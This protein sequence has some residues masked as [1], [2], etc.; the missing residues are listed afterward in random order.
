MRSMEGLR[1]DV[2]KSC[3]QVVTIADDDRE[4][5][6]AEVEKE[7]W[8]ALLKLAR[9]AIALFLARRAAAPRPLEYQHDG[10]DYVLDR[11][12]LAQSE[13]GTRFG[14]VAFK[15][16]VGRRADGRRGS[17]DL[18]SIANSGSSVGSASARSL[19]RLACARRWPLRPR[20][21]P[22]AASA[23]GRPA[24]ARSCAWSTRSG[25]R[26]AVSSRLRRHRLMT[27]RFLLSK[28]M[29]EVLP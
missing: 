1:R 2:H 27:A 22:S 18:P 4:R 3:A 9:C 19:R 25:P 8:T 7:L 23:S 15:R 5:S 26:R 24:S 21:R 11:R 10:V 14:K 12:R 13:I 17:R 20:V 28:S 6:L 16:P 29:A